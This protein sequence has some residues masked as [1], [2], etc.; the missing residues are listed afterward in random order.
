[1]TLEQLANRLQI[2][3]GFELSLA[4]FTGSS[5]SV[6][7]E[8]TA[9]Q[10]VAF[11][12][13]G[14]S[15][16]VLGEQAESV[17]QY[18]LTT[19]FDVSTASFSGTSFDVSAEETLPKAIAFNPDGTRMFII[20]SSSNSVH[21][22]SLST[23]FDLSTASFSGTSFDVSAEENQPEGIAFNPDGTRMFVIG[24]SSNS[25]HQYSLSTGFDL[26]T[27]SFTG[28]SFD[29]S[30]QSTTPRGV[31]FNPDGT[32]MFVIGTSADSVFQYSLSTAFDVSTASFTGISFDVSGQDINSRGVAFNPDGSGMFIIG[33]DNDSV[34]EY[35]VGRLKLQS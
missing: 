33:A 27:A 12:D 3:G 9:A 30:G 16:F 32:R 18:S 31:A 2:V 17:F 26:S 28:T 15:M 1:M 35:L 23:G 5:F 21:Q 20:G 13:D 22:Y 14:A 25:V 29:V 24:S 19:G 4:E 6:T 10:G 11:S 8:A 7:G 34:F